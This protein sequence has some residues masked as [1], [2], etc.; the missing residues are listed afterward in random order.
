MS[1]VGA[2]VGTGAGPAM[3]LLLR[4]PGCPGLAGGRSR[5]DVTGRRRAAA[6]GGCRRRYGHARRPATWWP[7]ELAAS[8]EMIARGSF[9]PRDLVHGGHDA[10][11]LAADAAWDDVDVTRQAAPG[12]TRVFQ[13]HFG[14]G[15]G[16]R[17]PR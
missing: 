9:D 8:A 4:L 13:L 12:G 7:A 1:L 2:G 14:D 16:R 10:I 17:G 15:R 5:G 11:R 3:G 6:L